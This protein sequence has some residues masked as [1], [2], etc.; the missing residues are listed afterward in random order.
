MRPHSDPSVTAINR[1]KLKSSLLAEATYD[2]SVRVLDVIYIE[3]KGYRFY[4]VP[5]SEWETF[6]ASDSPGR[7]FLDTI[8]KKYRRVRL[9]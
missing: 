5:A 6:A 9:P 7:Y 3:D 2:E 4:E 8:R 1:M